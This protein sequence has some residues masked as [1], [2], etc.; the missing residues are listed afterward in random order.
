MR[1]TLWRMAFWRIY[2][3]RDPKD[4]H[5]HGRVDGCNKK[6]V[7]IALKAAGE[8]QELY[9]CRHSDADVSELVQSQYEASTKV[10]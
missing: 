5:A 6:E 2:G 1:K 3:R 9:H 4:S 7:N 8:M 10:S